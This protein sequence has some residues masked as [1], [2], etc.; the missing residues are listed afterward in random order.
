MDLSLEGI[1][2]RYGKEWILKDINLDLRSG[3][4]TAITGA[5]GSGKSPLMKIIAGFLS[6]SKGNLEHTGVEAERYYK[7]V[8]MVAPYLDIYRDLNLEQQIRFHFSLR[9]YQE[10]MDEQ[11]LL[12]MIDLPTDRP[13]SS[14][15][16]GMTQRLKVGLALST[17]S[18]IV[19]MDEGTMNLDKQAME[20]YAKALQKHIGKRTLLVASNSEGVETDSCTRTFRII[21]KK[22]HVLE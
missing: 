3:S 1:G 22:L 9:E 8:S 19:I 20:W 16:S 7:E 18:S 21:E 17:R 4:H 13:I 2:K 5:N 10:G 14:Y 12:G 6:A 15:S 11:S